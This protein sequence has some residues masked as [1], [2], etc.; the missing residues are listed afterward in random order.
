MKVKQH[1][2][3]MPDPEGRSEKVEGRDVDGPSCPQLQLEIKLETKQEE[4]QGSC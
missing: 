4:L 2:V 1:E 3:R